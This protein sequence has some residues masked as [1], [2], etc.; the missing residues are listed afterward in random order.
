MTM[1]L[2]MGAGC[3]ECMKLMKKGINAK[4]ETSGGVMFTCKDC[5]IRVVLSWMFF[6]DEKKDEGQ[7][8]LLEYTR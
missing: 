4:D 3:P 8:S 5:G 1:V 7:Q 6:E 2:K